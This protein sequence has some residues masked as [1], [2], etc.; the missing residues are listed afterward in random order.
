VTKWDCLNNG[1][2]WLNNI[3]NYDNVLN[4]FICL[5]ILSSGESWSIC[6]RSATDAVGIDMVPVQGY[7]DYWAFYFMLYMVIG[8]LFMIN[9]FVSIVVN[10]YY[11]E[12]EKLYRNTLLSKYQKIWLQVQTLCLQEEPIKQIKMTGGLLKQT[13]VRMAQEDS[14]FGFFIF[15]CIIC[16]TIVM[17]INWYG[18]PQS[19]LNALEYT[20]YFFTVV[21]TVEAVIKLYAL[22]PYGYFAEGWNIFD[23]VLVLL[24]D[25]FLVMTLVGIASIGPKFSTVA[26]SLR[27]GRIFRLIGRARFLRVI[28][29]TIIVTLPSLAN[30]SALLML[31]L[32]IF[33]ILGMQLFGTVKLQSTFN[34]YANFQNFGISLLTLLRIQTGEN[35]PNMMVDVATKLNVANNCTDNPTYASIQANGG[36]VN[37]CGTSASFVY[38]ML[39]HLMVTVI[40][41]NLFVAVILNGFSNSNDEESF[42]IFK[43]QI[44]K[45]KKIW[46]EYDPQATGFVE[47]TKIEAIVLQLEADTDFITTGL[48]G[49]PKAIRQFIASLQIPSY[50]GFS[51]Y[52]MQDVLSTIAKKYICHRYVIEGLQT[53]ELQDDYSH[54]KQEKLHREFKF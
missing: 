40:F 54:V 17:A 49:N 42:Q 21:F 35:W 53:M 8:S 29:N 7:N 31:I 1:G 11:G 19:L 36:I 13:C 51:K 28:F 41:L 44:E 34:E 38:F 45:F 5:F 39:F 30:V 15:F 22:T 10:T 24:S 6:M 37:G 50:Q 2:D 25:I 26:R 18:A 14:W 20:N 9:L 32:T 16:N 52:F 4:S 33:A 23:F 48:R 3:L 47:V 43:V 27:I 46:Q 12:K